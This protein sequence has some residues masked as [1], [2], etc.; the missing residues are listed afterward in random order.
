MAKEQQKQTTGATMSTQDKNIIKVI[1]NQAQVIRVDRGYYP[2]YSHKLGKLSQGFTVKPLKDGKPSTINESANPAAL[3]YL[4]IFITYESKKTKTR[5]RGV[6]FP[7]SVSLFLTQWNGA[8]CRAVKFTGGKW[9]VMGNLWR[10]TEA[11]TLRKI[12]DRFYLLTIGEQYTPQDEKLQEQRRNNRPNPSTAERLR[13]AQPCQNEEET[14]RG[15]TYE[16][17]ENGT[18]WGLTYSRHYLDRSGYDLTTTRAALYRRARELRK[19]RAADNWNN[20]DHAETVRELEQI[21]QTIKA[22]AVEIFA[23]SGDFYPLEMAQKFRSAAQYV[24]E[25]A[26]QIKGGKV[27]N[28]EDITKRIAHSRRLAKKCAILKPLANDRHAY[29][30]TWWELTDSGELV[31][32]YTGRTSGD[33]YDKITAQ[34]VG[35]FENQTQ[36]ATL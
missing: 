34:S 36:G 28:V 18:R 27:E 32:T 26:E 22:A 7:G 8:T 9:Q 3:N 2:H 19:Q 16:T 21:A 13:G 30:W 35:I 14:Q 12:G 11:E 29:G 5:G 25:T 4:I 15:A 1:K 23:S 10:N 31:N 24:E 20:T 17:K 6:W 33:Y